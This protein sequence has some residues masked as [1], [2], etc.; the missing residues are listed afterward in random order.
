[1]PKII[2]SKDIS[3]RRI[4]QVWS[5]FPKS[6]TAQARMHGMKLNAY[7]MVLHRRKMFDELIEFSFKDITE[8][9]HVDVI[10]LSATDQV[11]RLGYDQCMSS[12]YREYCFKMRKTDTGGLRTSTVE[13]PQPRRRR[14]ATLGHNR[15][16]SYSKRQTAEITAQTSNVSSESTVDQSQEQEE[17]DMDFDGL[18]TT[19]DQIETVETPNLDGPAETESDLSFLLD[20]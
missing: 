13:A 4:R 16:I 11:K 19:K 3:D 1:M 15:G 18:F 6:I 5:M 10:A 8:K 20:D 14:G 17:W 7:K 12:M 2:V 9:Q